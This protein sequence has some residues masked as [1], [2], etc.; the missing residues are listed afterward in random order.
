MDEAAAAAPK[1][2]GPRFPP[3]P[4]PGRGRFALWGMLGP[5]PHPHGM[6][7]FNCS[8]GSRGR[9]TNRG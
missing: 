2:Q 4:S 3:I 7:P 5:Q 9:R 8:S 6:Q 1:P